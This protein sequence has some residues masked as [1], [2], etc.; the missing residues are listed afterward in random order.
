M[1]A[2]DLAYP[3]TH[4]KTYDMPMTKNIPTFRH[5]LRRGSKGV[6]QRIFEEKKVLEPLRELSGQ[7]REISSRVNLKI[8]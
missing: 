8:F 4:E 1:P 3:I 7:I 2:I 5:F 6:L